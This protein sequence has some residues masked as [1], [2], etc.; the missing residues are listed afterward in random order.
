MVKYQQLDNIFSS[1]SD[2]TRRN[3]LERLMDNPLTVSEIYQSYE[4]EMSLPAIS[5]HLKVL[6]NAKLVE[7][8]KEGRKYIFSLNP[9]NMKTAHNYIEYYSKFWT[10]K[11]DDLERYLGKGGVRNEP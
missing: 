8:R 2:S 11:L 9:K 7:R 6:E 1:L 3:I 4:K 10:N 5:K